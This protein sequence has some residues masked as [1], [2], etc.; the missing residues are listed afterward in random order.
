MQNTALENRECSEK[1]KNAF[2]LCCL[3][4]RVNSTAEITFQTFKTFYVKLRSKP[5]VL[6]FAFAKWITQ[7]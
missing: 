5:K 4:T 1:E 3:E 2:I 6:F 7:C